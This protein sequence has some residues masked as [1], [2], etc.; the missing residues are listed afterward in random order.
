MAYKF[1]KSEDSVRYYLRKLMKEG[2]I[3][4]EGSKKTGKWIGKENKK[5][6]DFNKKI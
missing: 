6:E 4:R 1:D 3:K 2:E 5:I